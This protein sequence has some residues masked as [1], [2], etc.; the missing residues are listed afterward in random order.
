MSHIGCNSKNSFAIDQEHI[1]FS[2]GSYETSFSERDIIIPRKF[3][4]KNVFDEYTVKGINFGHV[5]V[6]ADRNDKIKKSFDDIIKCLNF[7]KHYFIDIKQWFYEKIRS[8]YS[9]EQFIL[10]LFENAEKNK[11]TILI[12]MILK[13]IFKT[14][15]CL[16]KYKW[17]RFLSYGKTYFEKIKIALHLNDLKLDFTESD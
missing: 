3:N 1:L 15:F 5:T 13:I 2:C 4:V 17:K 6:I 16:F 9:N 10:F 14:I 7:G 12:I 8:V 11:M